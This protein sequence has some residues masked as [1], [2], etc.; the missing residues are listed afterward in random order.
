MPKFLYLLLQ[1]QMF[2][3]LLAGGS[4][5]AAEY[6]SFLLLF[7][8]LDTPLY[9]ANSLSFCC[10][11]VVSFLLNRTWAFKQDSFRM[12][13]HHQVG[14]YLALA[15]FN[16]LLINIAVGILKH[17]GI[18]PVLAK[19]SAMVFIVVWDFF[20]YRTFIFAGSQAEEKAE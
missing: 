5:F 13:G 17:L 1:K 3:Y 12:R 19:L 15:L 6:A 20:A 10:G 11:L 9:V 18:V 8:A 7:I 4:A 16:L 2:R 14:A